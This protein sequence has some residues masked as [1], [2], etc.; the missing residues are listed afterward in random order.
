MRATPLIILLSRGSRPWLAIAAIATAV[1]ALHALF[2]GTALAPDPGGYLLVARQWHGSGPLLY[3][4]LWVD[5]P[6]LLLVAFAVA[7]PFGALG[8]QVLACLCAGVL[9]VAAGWAGWAVAGNSA[10]RW[11]A[12]TAGAL[13][14]SVAIDAQNLDG[15]LLAAPLVMVSCAL[16]L[17]AVYRSRSLRYRLVLVVGAGIFAVGAMLVKQNFVDA[18][19]FAGILLVLPGSRTVLRGRD[20][21]TMLAMFGASAAAVLAVVAA[22]AYSHGQLH[23]LWFATYTFRA[24]A[25][26]VISAGS[27]HAP[28]A[29]LFELFWLALFSGV[30]FLLAGAVLAHQKS[31]RRADPFVAAMAAG[32]LVELTG[33]ALGGS[34]WPH[35]LIGLIPMLALGA[36]VAAARHASWGFVSMRLVIVASAVVSLISTPTAALVAHSNPPKSERTATWLAGVADPTDTVIVTFSHPNVIEASGLSTVYPYVWSLPARTLDPDL[37]LFEATVLGAN[38]PTWIVEWEPFNT[39]QLDPHHH[40]ADAIAGRYRKVARVCNHPV[41]LRD[42][43]GRAIPKPNVC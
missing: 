16:V 2:L 10:A 23:A 21:L 8:V 30:A 33:I 42:D 11:C 1:M 41:W 29:R 28:Q 34:F 43:V 36:G 35:Y 27:W 19:A 31:L 26:A 39:W 32:L 5:R 6:P 15:E 24:K 38:A 14:T 18:F 40:V 4:N 7:G 25:G 3:G 12:L 9:V 17:H 22:W 13:S 20:R 37:R